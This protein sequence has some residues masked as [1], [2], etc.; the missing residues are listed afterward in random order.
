MLTTHNRVLSILLQMQQI[1]TIAP[2]SKK[3]TKLALHR[4]QRK[5]KSKTCITVDAKKHRMQRNI[6]RLK[7]TEQN[8]HTN[9]KATLNRK[10]PI[11]HI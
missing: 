5:Q 6:G 10:A 2:I 8:L 1:I 11:F 7:S 4:M 3:R 9:G